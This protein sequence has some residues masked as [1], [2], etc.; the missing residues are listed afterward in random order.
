MTVMKRAMLKTTPT[1]R[2]TGGDENSTFNSCLLVLNEICWLRKRFQ[3]LVLQWTIWCQQA[4]NLQGLQGETT[5]LSPVD[6]LL[7]R[8]TPSSGEPELHQ[9]SPA[10]SAWVWMQTLSL[11]GHKSPCTLLFVPVTK[12][13]S[14]FAALNMISFSYSKKLR[15]TFVSFKCLSL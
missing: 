5:P 11:D 12:H 15:C 3:G 1:T 10:T 2:P 14:T 9:D 7:L 13:L 4:T 8:W 6:S